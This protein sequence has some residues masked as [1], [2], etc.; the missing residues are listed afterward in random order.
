MTGGKG[1]CAC[2]E[3]KYSFSGDAVGTALCHCLNCQKITGSAF[4]SVL[5]IPS[6]HFRFEDGAPTKSFTV[7]HHEEGIEIRPIFCAE[8][9][10]VVCKTAE[11][12]RFRG[13][14]MVMAGTLD[15]E[16]GAAAAVT[17]PQMELWTK[18]RLAW[19]KPLEV[20]QFVGFAG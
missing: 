19:V 8:C 9:G 7:R 11:D 10:T 5:L 20:K 15:V 2:G 1:S 6:A 13:L 17:A 16:V 4:S 14:H 12:E 3:T 18:H